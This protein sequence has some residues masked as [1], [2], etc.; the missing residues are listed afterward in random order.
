MKAVTEKMSN[1]VGF[2]EINSGKKPADF[3][4]N[5]WKFLG[6]ISLKNDQ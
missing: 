2:S 3:A 1:Y 6:Q 4:E 5:S